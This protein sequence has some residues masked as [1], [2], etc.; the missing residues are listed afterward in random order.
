M[1]LLL[2]EDDEMLGAGIR[3]A[4]ASESY[5]VD[6]LTDGEQAGRSLRDHHYDLIVLDLGLPGA[7]G[8]DLLTALRRRVDKVPVLVL[9]ARD[10]VQDR[11]RGLDAGADDYLVKPF[12]VGELK[13][14]IRA[15][16]RRSS[17]RVSEVIEQGNLTLDLDA[18]L[19]RIDGELMPLT[20]REF[21]LLRE[22]LE[23]AGQVLTRERLEQALYG[24]RE[25]VESNAL[26]V[27]IHHLRKKLGSEVIRTVRGVGYLVEKVA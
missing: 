14:R 20:R 16:L 26:E 13:A 10:S 24:W 9:T 6:W 8:L 4:L 27:H 25:E 1:R 15:L 2:V 5:Q 7:N 22:L 23:H 18:Q 12:D 3:D 21:S 19:L 11:I 17:G